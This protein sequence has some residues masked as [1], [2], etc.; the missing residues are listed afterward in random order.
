MQYCPPLARLRLRTLLAIPACLGAAAL[1]ALPSR[2]A[3]RTPATR[4]WSTRPGRA[5]ST[6]A[7]LL[8]GNWAPRAFRPRPTTSASRRDPEPAGDRGAA[9]RRTR[10]ASRA[11]QPIAG[12]R[13]AN[14]CASSRPPSPRSF[15]TTSTSPTAR[16]STTRLADDRGQPRVELG[17]DPAIGAAGTTTIAPGGTTTAT[18]REPALPRPPDASHR[19]HRRPSPATTPTST[20]T[21]PTPGRRRDRDRLRR[22]ARPSRTTR[23]SSTTAARPHLVH[24][25]TG[26]TL[27]RSAAARPRSITVPLDND[28]TVNAASTRGDDSTF[29]AAATSRPRTGSSTPRP[30]RDR[31]HRR[32]PRRQRLDLHRRRHRARQLG[33][34]DA[35]PGRPRSPRRRRST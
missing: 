21:T 13:R 6:A 20:T 1:L 31:L 34:L 25:Q 9:R 8:A 32:H 29:R 23:T 7:G 35:P 11:S 2:P 33:Q 10:A 15:T 30:A 16:D 22:H 19:R 14:S 18:G 12:H 3:L 4:G 27:T 28:G 5:T 24:V 26:G 17:D